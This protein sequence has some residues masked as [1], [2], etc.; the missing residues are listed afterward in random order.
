M[1]K[2]LDRLRVS[3]HDDH[4]GDPTVEGLGRLVRALLQLLVIG[5][6]L[7]QVQNGVVELQRNKGRRRRTQ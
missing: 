2:N 4:F 6:L 1:E 5:G 3:R 7:N